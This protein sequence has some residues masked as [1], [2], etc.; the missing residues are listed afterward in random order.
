MIDLN[1]IDLSVIERPCGGCG[2][3][4]L[5]LWRLSRMKL[6]ASSPERRR[7]DVLTVAPAIGGHI[8]GRRG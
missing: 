8:I 7:E 2:K 1:V 3:C 4:L 5:C 6:A